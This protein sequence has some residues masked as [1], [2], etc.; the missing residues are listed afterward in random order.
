MEKFKN[1]IDSHFDFR[2]YPVLIFSIIAAALIF[3]CAKFLPPNF[4]YENGVIENIQMVVLT[5]SLLFAL[6]AKSGKR[7]FYFVALV[8]FLLS[9]REINYGRTIFFP[10][11]GEV[12]TYYSWKEIKY[13]WL[14]NPLVGVY[15]ASGVLYFIFGKACIQMWQIIKSVKFPIW[16]FTFLFA[17][18][19]LGIFAEKT[20]QSFVMEEA[21]ELL[22]YVS[23]MGIIWL[24]AF[25]KNFSFEEN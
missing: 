16:N 19:I 3:P 22:F 8:I 1:F 11:P 13:G 4:G 21:C 20:G 15:I 2:F 25:N 18:M 14:V 5:L 9:A 17:G 12:N 24:Y 10:V 6:F 23:L 7:F